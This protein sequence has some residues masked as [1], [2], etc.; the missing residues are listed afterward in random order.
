MPQQLVESLKARTIHWLPKIRKIQLY[1]V[2][3]DQYNYINEYVLYIIV[4]LNGAELSATMRFRNQ[5]A[6]MWICSDQT[7]SE[8]SK[9][10][11]TLMDRCT[12]ISPCTRDINT[13]STAIG[14]TTFFRSCCPFGLV[15]IL[16]NLTGG[17]LSAIS[18][19]SFRSPWDPG[20]RVEEDG[21][22]FWT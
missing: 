16:C 11:T 13:L 17:G 9:M 20:S 18:C 1:I 15:E 5:I 8:K 7:G 21:E 4:I 19:P 2:I 12:V 6:F 10:A 14:L 3:I 22:S